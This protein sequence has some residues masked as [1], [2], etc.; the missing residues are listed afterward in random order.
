MKLRSLIALVP[1]GIFTGTLSGC[2]VTPVAVRPAYAAPAGVVYIEP[3]YAIP[4]R[5]YRW[6]HHGHHG[7][8]W[9]HHRHGWHRGWR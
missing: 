2:I 8:G 6:A 9:H 4:A 7:W 5:G 3:T 1:V